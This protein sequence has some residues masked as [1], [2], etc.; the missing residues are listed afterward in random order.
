MQDYH[1]KMFTTKHV[2]YLLNMN[3]VLSVRFKCK[4]DL[5]TKVS[6]VGKL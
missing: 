4:I 5:D 2:G 6:V 3:V 1:A